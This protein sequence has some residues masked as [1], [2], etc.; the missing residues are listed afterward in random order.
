MF[1][2]KIFVGE[3][4]GDFGLPD[5]GLSPKPVYLSSGLSLQRTNPISGKKSVTSFPSMLS[6]I[7]QGN[8]DYL[9][10]MT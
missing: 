2:G 9:K 7:S 8:K 4:K 5:S 1:Q 3:N 10:K 6:C